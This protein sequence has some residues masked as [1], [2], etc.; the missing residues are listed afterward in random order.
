MKSNMLTKF[1]LMLIALM[2]SLQ[3]NLFL[4]AKEEEKAVITGNNM[5]FRHKGMLTIYKDGVLMK[6]GKSWL[7][8]SEAIYNEE[9]EEII[10]EGNIRIFFVQEEGDVIE[11]FGSSARYDR[12]SQQGTL[13]GFPKAI[14]RGSGEDADALFLYADEIKFYEKKG[15]VKALGNVYLANSNMDIWSDRAE[16][17]QKKEVVVMTGDKPL[18]VMIDD[19]GV[20]YFNSDKITILLNTE[21]LLLDRSVEGIVWGGKKSASSGKIK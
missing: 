14:I 19:S 10:I 8:A 4:H 1:V 3:S 13:Y 9:T 2:F 20:N 6:K 17:D 16:Y 5:E 15:Y 7:K 18:I 11:A 12:S 21:T